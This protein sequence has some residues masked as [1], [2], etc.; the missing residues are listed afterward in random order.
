LC[1]LTQQE[2]V[3]IGVKL[4]AP[5]VLPRNA[6]ASPSLTVGKLWRMKWEDRINLY[7]REGYWNEARKI[8]NGR[9]CY[10]LLCI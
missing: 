10:F 2:Y 8:S 1:I 9:H 6:P 4:Y 7:L 5:L 3:T